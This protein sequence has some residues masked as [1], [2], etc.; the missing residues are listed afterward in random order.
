[1]NKVIKRM[2]N[3][4][5]G[6]LAVVLIYVLVGLVLIMGEKFKLTTDV[7]IISAFIL[8]HGLFYIIRYL[9]D[10]LGKKVFA[11]DLVMGVVGIILGIFTYVYLMDDTSKVL[12]M[13]G[14]ILGI[15]YIAIAVEKLFFGVKF[16]MAGEETSTLICF[17]GA[18]IGAM[19]ILLIFNPFG[20][21]M[22][23][24]RLM[25]L[26]TICTGILDGMTS[27]LFRKRAKEILK[28]FE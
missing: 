9:Y 25:G 18:L 16:A 12:N 20:S 2:Q 21:F 22:L 3:L 15:W 11:I 10:G 27:M 26:F 6:S 14:I 8:V 17:M 4:M 19:G 24:T 28:L 23:I 1:M 5:I 13:I 7:V